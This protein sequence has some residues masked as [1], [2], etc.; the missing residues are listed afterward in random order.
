MV[1]RDRARLPPG[2]LAGRGAERVPDRGGTAVVCD[3]SLE[4]ERLPVRF[5]PWQEGTE[6]ADIAAS[7]IGISW[8]PDDPWSRGKCGLK[9]LQYMAAGLI[10]S[11]LPV[12]FYLIMQRYIV[13]GLTAGAVKGWAFQPPCG[14]AKLFPRLSGRAGCGLARPRWD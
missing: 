9:V 5:C 12:F 7:D 2:H 10:F 1:G 4:L 13:A 11:I 3:R 6:A 8:L 14:L